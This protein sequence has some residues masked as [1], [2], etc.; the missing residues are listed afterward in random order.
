MR[1][2]GS[3]GSGSGLGIAAFPTNIPGS[4]GEGD[5]YTSPLYQELKFRALTIVHDYL[6]KR[7]FTPDKANGEVVRGEISRA[8]SVVVAGAGVALNAA[9]RERL[10]DDVFFEIVGLGP[11]EPLLADTTVDDIIVNGPSRI[12][13]ERSGVLERVTTRFRDDAHL[14]NIIQRIVSPIGRRVD[15]A[16]PFVDARLKDGS[17][18]NIV[19]PPIALDGAT[20]SIRKFKRIPLKIHDLVRTGTISQEMVDYLAAAVR[21]RLNVLIS[22]GTGSGKTTML[23]ILSGFISATERIVTIEDAAELQLRQSH[24]VRLETRPPSADGTPEITA[25]DLVKNALRM[26]PDRII[27]GEIRSGEAVEMVQAMTTGHDGSMATVHA[28]SP[29]DA[30]SRLELL[31][32]FGGMQANVA[33]VRRQITSAVQVVVQVQRLSSGARKVISIAEV[34]GMEG[35]TIVQNERFRYRENPGQPGQGTFVMVT[36]HSAFQERLAT[37]GGVQPVGGGA[38][39]FEGR[40]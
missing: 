3:P 36:R 29:Q 25:R 8:I 2:A 9:E 35:E 13:V 32:G 17:R 31:L 33:T 12:Y 1:E 23:N 14:M 4:R 37:V 11:L 34:V 19:I 20:V 22:G 15:E 28:N 7:G 21:S 27:L 18:V 24:V 10:L 5:I 40:P 30:M 26:R 6:E 16:S 39:R 38:G